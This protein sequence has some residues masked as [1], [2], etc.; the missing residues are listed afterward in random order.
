VSLNSEI[1]VSP[2]ATSP[3]PDYVQDISSRVS[4]DQ[5]NGNGGPSAGVATS[6]LECP[7]CL[8]EMVGRVLV[9]ALGMALMGTDD[10]AS[11]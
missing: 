2:L 10:A 9:D 6:K 5:N 11:T 8:E 1:S 7:I 4:L 3:I